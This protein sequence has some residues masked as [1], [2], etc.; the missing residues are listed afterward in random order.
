MADE[1]SRHY[2]VVTARM[3]CAKSA[4]QVAMGQPV[5]TG[6]LSKAYPGFEETGSCTARPLCAWNANRVANICI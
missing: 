5:H 4:K 1:E 2:L 3:R 6:R